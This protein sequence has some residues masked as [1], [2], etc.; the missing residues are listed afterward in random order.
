MQIVLEV[1]MSNSEDIFYGVR[2]YKTSEKTRRPAKTAVES[3]KLEQRNTRQRSLY[4]TLD[5]IDEMF[6][7][8]EK[9]PICYD[10]LFNLIQGK[11]TKFFKTRN[12]DR[13]KEISY[14]CLNR[15]YS[16]LK[17]KLLKLASEGCTHPSLRFYL[18]QFFRYVELVVYSTVFYGTKDQKYLV[19]EPD[20]FMTENV[21]HSREDGYHQ[22]EIESECFSDNSYRNKYGVTQSEDAQ[23][24]IEDHYGEEL[25]RYLQDPNNTVEGFIEDN[26]ENIKLCIENNTKL[27]SKE[28]SALFRL[29]RSCYSKYGLAALTKRDKDIVRILSLRL[30]YEPDLLGNLKELLD[31]KG[32]S[33]E[34]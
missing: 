33:T 11:V 18:S 34:D 20:D 28:K 3:T 31:G 27:D 2:S 16:I 14:D 5:N 10:L 19:Q 8:N 4:I 15:L 12:Y 30:E 7:P 25:E 24:V 29:Y 13:K 21:L 26:S 17:R 23:V 22:Y 6:S 1:K 9:W 32:T